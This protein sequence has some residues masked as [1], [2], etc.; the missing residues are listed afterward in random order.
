MFPG[1]G[2]LS[3][4]ADGVQLLLVGYSDASILFRS[5]VHGAGIG[6]SGVLDQGPAA[7]YWSRTSSAFLASMGFVR[8]GREVTGALPGGT[9]ILKGIREQEPKSVFD[10]EKTSWN[11]QRDVAQVVDHR[12]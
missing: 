12:W 1:D 4:G 5:G 11:S 7:R 2:K 3:D 8:Y 10:V 6:R 9:E